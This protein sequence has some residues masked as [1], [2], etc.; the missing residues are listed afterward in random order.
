HSAATQRC[1]PDS[2]K[3]RDA[4]GQTE[5]IAAQADP[6][7]AIARTTANVPE[8]YPHPPLPP[9]PRAATACNPHIEPQAAKA[10]EPPPHSAPHS[11]PINPATAGQATT[12]PPRCGAAQAKALARSHQAQINAPAAALHAQDQTKLATLA[13]ALPQAPLRLQHKPKPADAPNSRPKQLAA[14]PHRA[15]EIPSASS[16]AAQLRPQAQLPPLQH[17]ENR[18]A[19]PPAGS[20]SPHDLLPA[21]P[22]TTADAAQTTTELPQDAKPDAA[23][24]AQLPHP[25]AD[26]PAMP[27]SALQTGC[28][29]IPQ[30]QGSTA[31]G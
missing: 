9:K 11:S 5:A 27:P 15:P 28:G 25:Q 31:A 30:H 18:S 14:L 4:H 7:T 6:P 2:S 8:R 20:C 24:H 1:L 17:Q 22:K 12:H 13:S 21:A 29:S 19:V 3:P 23:A 26:Q 10:E 16:R